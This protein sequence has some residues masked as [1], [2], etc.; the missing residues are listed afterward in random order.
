MRLKTFPTRWG[1]QKLQTTRTVTAV[2]NPSF[3]QT[4]SNVTRKI[5]LKTS[6]HGGELTVM[7]MEVKS[8]WGFRRMKAQSEDLFSSALHR[9]P[10]GRSCMQT[11]NSSQQFCINFFKNVRQKVSSAGSC[12]STRTFATFREQ[13]RKS[14]L[15]S[16]PRSFQFLQELLRNSPTQKVL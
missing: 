4:L 14:Q 8:R 9:D 11:R 10:S 6:P 16:S 1:F 7:G 13:L 5:G 2:I 3:E 12:T 15:C